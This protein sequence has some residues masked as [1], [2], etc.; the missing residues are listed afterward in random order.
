MLQEIIWGWVR[1]LQWQHG[2]ESLGVFYLNCIDPGI[3][4][5]ALGKAVPANS[6]LSLV[7]SCQ[8]TAELI[9]ENVEAVL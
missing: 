1:Y 4:D 7:G 9:L 8:M 3:A 2:Q 6:V 5:G